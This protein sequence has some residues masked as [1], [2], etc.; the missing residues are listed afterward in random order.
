MAIPN[1]Y[2]DKITKDGKSRPISPAAEK[3]RVDNDNFEG[4]NLDDVLDEIHTAIGD[5]GSGDGTVTGVKVGNTPYSPDGEGVVDLSTPFNAKVDK[6][7]GKSLMTDAERTKLQNLPVNPVQSIS[8][9]GQTQTKDQNGNVNIEVNASGLTK[10]DISVVSQGDGTVDINVGSGADKDTYTID[11]NH[12]HENMAKL[13]VCEESDL[14]S[15]LAN[16]TI[17]AITDSGETEIEKLIIKGMEFAGGVPDT[18]MPQVT[19]PSVV[20]PLNLGTNTGSGVTALVDVKARN[21]NYNGSTDGLTVSVGQNSGLLLSYDQTVDATSITIP[22]L[23]AEMGCQITVKYTGSGALDDG[24]LVF[25]HDN[26]VLASVV[27]VVVVAPIPLSAIKLTGSQWLQTD[28]EPNANTEFELEIMLAGFAGG[29]TVQPIFDCEVDEDEISSLPDPHVFRCYFVATDGILFAN[30]F[31]VTNPYTRAIQKVS[32]AAVDGVKGIIK[33]VK[34][35]VTG[36][37]SNGV[38]SGGIFSCGS[39]SV[40]TSLKS[41]TM[42]YPLKIGH[43][44]GRKTDSNV[45]TSFTAFTIYR[46]TITEGGV[47]VRNYVPATLNG[48]PGLYETTGNGTK[49]F[50][51]SETS[52]PVVAI[53]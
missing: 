36:T 32:R 47:T 33:Y 48:I 49:R 12:T 41:S 52:T 40:E 28:Y 7:T 29:S 16:D 37:A 27:V 39:A 31:S 8:V 14:P 30:E 1:N 22:Q 15:T 42:K 43:G 26:A 10:D 23:A 51:S 35:A 46:L 18:G 17:Y 25:S 19:K 11:L 4:D 38:Q 34:G 5:A 2:I 13:I 44:R 3:V 24:A 9:N 21:L 53:E 45:I 20:R 6:E 50:L